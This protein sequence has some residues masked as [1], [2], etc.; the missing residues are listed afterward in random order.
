MA[1]ALDAIMNAPAFG[2]ALNYAFIAAIGIAALLLFA[3]LFYVVIMFVQYRNRAIILDAERYGAA[4]IKRFREIPKNSEIKFLMGRPNKM[5]TPPSDCF[6]GFGKKGKFLVA[7][8]DGNQ[9][10]PLKIM[11]NHASVEA[12]GDF[13]AIMRW[14]MADVKETEE[15]YKKKE[16]L[17][18]KI[19]PYAVIIIGALIHLL[20][21]ILIL[22][23]VDSAIDIGRAAASGAAHAGQ[24]LIT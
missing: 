24:Q 11:D 5:A 4:Q 21:I 19:A 8:K 10:I 12:A 18:L 3:V 13:K 16:S 14:Y 15:V 7:L 23:R 20:L 17:F 6:K 1:E 9:F 22:K 2:N